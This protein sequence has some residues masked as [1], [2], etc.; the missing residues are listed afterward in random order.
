MSRFFRVV[1]VIALFASLGLAASNFEIAAQGKK[2]EKK[3]KKQE[4][5]EKKEEKKEPFKPDVPTQEFTYVVK[6]EKDETG[7]TYWVTGL[8]FGPDSK[9][10]AAYYRD[11]VIKVWDLAAKK[12]TVSIKPPTIK[13]LGEYRGLVFA[14]GKLFVGTGELIKMSKEKEKDKDKAKEKDKER[15][16]RFGE[17]KSFDANTGKPGPTLI[18]HTL[19]IDALAISRDGKELASG[20]E[21]ATAKIWNIATGK[22]TQTFKGHTDSVT[23]VAF[24]PDGKQLAT[25][26]LDRTLRVWD[27]AGAKEIALFKI[28]REVETKDAKGKITKTKE[29]AR[30]FTGA[31]FTADGKKVIAANRD[32]MIKIYDIEA[33]KELQEMK[34]AEGIVAFAITSDA[35]KFA[36]G[37]YDG[38]IKIWSA[39]GKELKTIKAHVHPTRTGEPGPVISLSFSPDGASL[40]SGGVDGVVKIWSAK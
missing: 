15:P 36:V 24:S 39:E 23:G 20:S 35:G 31:A 5:K 13:G 3:D 40:A 9:F 27:I 1:F 32:G 26:S 28:E 37:G 18:G 8:A 17:I 38:L 10:V 29:L 6:G 16:F 12:D 30:D 34:A 11:N 7:K 33:K 21:D 25:T 19:N 22:D 14:D 2:D 4:P